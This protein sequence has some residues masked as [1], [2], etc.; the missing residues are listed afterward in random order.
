MEVLLWGILEKVNICSNEALWRLHI[1]IQK[2]LEINLKILGS[3]SFTGWLRSL[4]Y[5]V[6]QTTADT[7]VPGQCLAMDV[8]PAYASYRC[9]RTWLQT[10]WNLSTDALAPDW[11]CTSHGHSHTMDA[12]MP[13][14]RCLTPGRRCP[15]VRLQMLSHKIARVQGDARLCKSDVLLPPPPQLGF[16]CPHHLLVY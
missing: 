11:R 3:E 16:E 5:K 9:S 1:F 14:H 8:L 2:I 12:L 6:D 7:L 13:G 10:L 4:G 15:H